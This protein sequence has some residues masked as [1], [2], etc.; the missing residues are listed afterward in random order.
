MPHCP[1]RGLRIKGAAAVERDRFAIF[2]PLTAPGSGAYEEDGEG[3]G[4]RSGGGTELRN[5]RELTRWFDLRCRFGV[6]GC[7]EG[8]QVCRCGEPGGRGCDGVSVFFQERAGFA[9]GLGDP[10]A[11]HGE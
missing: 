3:A 1:S 11:V 8:D 4:R 7:E 10:A 9:D 6:L 2:D 5:R